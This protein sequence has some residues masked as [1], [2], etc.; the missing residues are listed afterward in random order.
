LNGITPMVRQSAVLREVDQVLPD[1]A[2][3]LLGAFNNVVGTSLFPRY[4]EP[5]AP[6]RIVEV[7]PGPKRLLHDPDVEDAAA[8][9]VKIRGTNDCGRG[10]EGSGFVYSDG[11]VMT[12]AHVVAGVDDPEVIMGDNSLPAR[13]VYYNADIDVAVLDVDTGSVGT[14]DF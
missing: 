13:T 6:E 9:V 11:K 4:L 8:S 2:S 5:F 3:S 12:N 10:V 7:G 1:A 14:L